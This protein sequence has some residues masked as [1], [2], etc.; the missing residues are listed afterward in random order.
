[1]VWGLGFREYYAAIRRLNFR[2]AIGFI[3]MLGLFRELTKGV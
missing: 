2:D 1:M 3:S